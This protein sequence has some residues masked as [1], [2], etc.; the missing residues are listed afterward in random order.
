MVHGRRRARPAPAA[1]CLVTGGN[2]ASAWPPPGVRRRR[3]PGGGHLAL[4]SRPTTPTASSP[5]AATSPTPSRS[6]PPSPR[7]RPSSARSRSWCPT[8]AS[9][10]TACVRMTDD[11]FDRRARRQPHRRLPG[12]RRAVRPM[13]RARWGRIVFMS[14]VVGRHRR[15][16]AGQLRR[17]EGRPGRPGPLAGPRV[18][19]PGHHRQRRGP[20]AHRHRHDRTPSPT[21]AARPSPTP[22]PLGRSGTPDEVAAAIAFL[23]SDEAGYITGAVV[24]V[25]GGLGMGTSSP[26]ATRSTEQESQQ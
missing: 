23:A 12:R 7:S 11:D 15:A 22:C 13:M 26:I 17:V 4:A 14:S 10:A 21:T 2:R 1:P 20:R 3:A 16:R 25:D 19:L 5:C 8:P 9:P 18:R 24:P 6:T